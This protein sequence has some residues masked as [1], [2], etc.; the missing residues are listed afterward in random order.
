MASRSQGS[1]RKQD[2][3]TRGHVD[4][5]VAVGAAIDGG[6]AADGARRRRR[7]LRVQRKLHVAKV[8]RG[9]GGVRQARRKARTPEAGALAQRHVRHHGNLASETQR[10]RVG[11]RVRRQA[12]AQRLDAAARGR[13]HRTRDLDAARPARA[14]AA[15]VDKL[16][17]AVVGRD[18]APQ[19][20]GADEL[21]AAHAAEN[22]RAV[23]RLEPHRE[24]LLGVRSKS[25]VV[26]R[27]AADA[28]RDAAAPALRLARPAERGD[29]SRH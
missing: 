5:S 13:F 20:C 6:A 2:L 24:E 28:P 8:R 15:A 17:L 22:A 10:P 23:I 12:E 11:E 3:R 29:A 25:L 9:L 1:P 21:A 16:A 4:A 14:Q 19:Q 26:A 27:A 18:A 7:R